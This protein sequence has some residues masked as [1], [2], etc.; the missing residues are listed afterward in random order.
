MKKNHSI[1]LNR[2]DLLKKAGIGFPTILLLSQSKFKIVQAEE[3]EE[4]KEEAVSPAEDLMREHGVLNRVLLIYKE[5]DS[6]IRANRTFSPKI[7]LDTSQLV[8]DFIEDYHEKLEED[9][10]F[11]RFEKEIRLVELV[12]VLRKQHR[13]GRDITDYLIAHS[14]ESSLKETGTRKQISRYLALF[15]HMYLAHESRE[16][17]VLFPAFKNIVSPN[18]YWALGEEF[19]AKEHDLFGDDGFETVV[20]KV[21][22]FEKE[23]GIDDLALYTPTI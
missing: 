6:R 11:P 12:Q 2:R 10:L 13:V 19:E 7:L 14:S 9:Y 23:L 18:E 3:S 5:V 20:A 16:D 8:R 15:N 4:H 17:T 1:Q 22:S 21:S